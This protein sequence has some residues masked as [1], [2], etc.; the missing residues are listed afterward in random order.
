MVG[1]NTV[2]L[3]V[4]RVYSRPAFGSAENVIITELAGFTIIADKVRKSRAPREVMQRKLLT[5]GDTMMARGHAQQA[6]AQRIRAVRRRRGKRVRSARLLRIGEREFRSDA[7]V[8]SGWG[9]GGDRA[10]GLPW[11]R[12]N[13]TGRLRHGGDGACRRLRWLP[14]SG[15]V[16]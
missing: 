10:G 12:R 7:I 16:I 8:L 3:P 4:K 9:F 5:L 14:G 6:G 2:A 1:M 13:V 11:R 15:A